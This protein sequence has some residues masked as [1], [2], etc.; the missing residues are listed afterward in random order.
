MSRVK[1]EPIGQA[2]RHRR[3]QLG[4]TLNELAVK[5]DISKP[6]LSL[7]ETGKTNGRI[8]DDFAQALAG[9]LDMDV[10]EVRARC[11]AEGVMRFVPAKL[12]PA[13]RDA[14]DDLFD[15]AEGATT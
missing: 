6:Y 5:S 11:M 15:D 9:A 10:T 4:L 2:F 7:I 1:L 3:R 8:A 13:L 12:W 14:L